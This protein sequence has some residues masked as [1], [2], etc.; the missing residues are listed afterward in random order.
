MDSDSSLTLACSKR[1]E[2]KVALITGGASGIG[3]C[4]AKLFVL[5]GAKVVIADIQDDLGEMVS[6]NLGSQETISY[7]H[8]DVTCDSDVKNAVDMAVSKYGKLD[9]MFNNAGVIGTC[10]APRIL[11]VENEEFK[12][13][14]DV[15]LFGAFLGAKHAAR[16]MIPAKKGCIL[17]TGSVI[18]ATCTGATPHPYFASKHAVVG[19]AK[20]LAVELGGHGIR[21]NCISPFAT[22]T[23][24]ITESMGIEKRK[25]EE[26][27]SSSSAILKEVLLEPEDIANAAVYLASDES[28]YVSGINLVIDGGYSLINPTLPSAVKSLLS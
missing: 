9:I 24:M 27:I 12:R 3:E 16:V 11:D 1:L 7:I 8:C 4:T 17:F 18:T 5:H 22:A 13:V 28:K 2:G 25:I 20:N 6:K 23:P 19:L 14:L 26:F 10:K 21:V 15:N